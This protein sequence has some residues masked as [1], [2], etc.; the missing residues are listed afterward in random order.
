[1]KI[2][3]I[4][5][6]H[7]VDGKNTLLEGSKVD[8][9]DII[10]KIIVDEGWIQKK[11]NCDSYPCRPYCHGWAWEVFKNMTITMDTEIDVPYD[12]S[13]MFSISTAYFGANYNRQCSLVAGTEDR[14]LWADLHIEK[15]YCKAGIVLSTNQDMFDFF[16]SHDTM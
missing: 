5:R 7:T 6:S 2:H 11:H 15:L 4:G 13:M 12:D 8:L 10:D 1:M 14:G 16:L 9:W 3:Q